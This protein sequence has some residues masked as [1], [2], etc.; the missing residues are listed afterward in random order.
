[1][2]PSPATSSGEDP[3][4]LPRASWSYPARSHHVPR[5]SLHDVLSYFEI[6]PTEYGRRLIERWDESGPDAFYLLGVRAIGGWLDFINALS[7]PIRIPDHELAKPRSPADPAFVEMQHHAYLEATLTLGDSI[8]A[9]LAGYPRPAA[10]MIRPFVET[11]VSEVYVHGDDTGKRLWDYLRFL[12]GT[13]HRPRYR[14]MLNAIFA[15]PR[16]AALASFRQR[17]DAVYGASSSGLHVHTVDD[18][19]LHMRDANRARATYPEVVFWFASL[20]IAVQRMLTLLTLRYPMV[21][22]PVDVRRRFGYGGPMN[23]FADEVVSASI[24]DGLGARHADALRGY[25]ADDPEVTSLLS[26]FESQPVL[27]DR[28]LDAEWEEFVS[29]SHDGQTLSELRQEARWAAHRSLL[30]TSTWALDLTSAQQLIPEP[31]DFEP[32]DAIERE[33]IA[34]ELRPFYNRPP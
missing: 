17:V 34:T 25:L 9:G 12:A 10:A 28:D 14:G 24:A 5:S 15:E 3:F 4:V 32:G 16:F 11:A 21:L 13:G 8:A 18:G 30:A 31:P 22:F 1:M 26:Y 2:R 6:A 20:G 29:R 7:M 19:L 23:L 33:L 27:T